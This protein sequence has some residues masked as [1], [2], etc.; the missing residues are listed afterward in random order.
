MP[1]YIQQSRNNLETCHEDLQ[2]IF[3]HVI[4]SFDNSIIC[5]HRDEQDQNEAYLTGASTVTWPNSNHNALPS[6]AVDSAP[7]PIDWEDLPRF[8]Y[9]AGYVMGIARMLYDR[10]EIDH[11]L[12]WGGDWDR[13]TLTHDNTFNDLV[14]F[15]L[16]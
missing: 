3:N 11:Q 9:Y 13:D 1:S 10:C 15:E 8:R 12:R 5:G 16:I 14:H 2:I 7:W 4:A 6:K